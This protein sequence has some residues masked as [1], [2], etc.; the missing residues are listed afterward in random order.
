MIGGRCLL[1]GATLLIAPTGRGVAGEQPA[2]PVPARWSVGDARAIGDGETDHTA[3]FQRLLDE[4]GRAGGGVVEVPA[5]RYVIRGSLS[6]PSGVT[7]QGTYR[8]PPTAR[9]GAVT[10]LTGTVLLAYAGR[11]STNG[12]PFISLAG[13]CA[14][15]SGLI[16]AYP[17]WRQEDVPPVPYPPCVMSRGTENVGVLDC[18]LLNPYEAIRLES[19]HR[20][21][22]RNV[23][24]YPS[25]RGLYVDMCGDIG[26][27]ENVHFWPFGVM[28]KPNNPFCEWVNTQGVAF[29]LA[30]TDWE[31][32]LN[33]FCFGYGIGYRFSQSKHGSANGNFLGI[34]ADSCQ[35]AVVVEQAQ[36][37]GLLISNGEFVGRWSSTDAVCLEIGPAAEGKVSLSNCSF[38]GPID[39]CVWMRSPTGQFTAGACNFLNWDNRGVGSPAIQLDAGRAIIQGCTF[40]Q[41]GLHVQVG[42]EV[43]SAILTANQ[44]SGGFFVENKAGRRA[45]IAL[46]EEGAVQW[47]REALLNYRLQVGAQGD[48]RYLSGWHGRDGGK[49]PSRWSMP[50]SRLV[51]PVAPGERYSIILEAQVPSVAVSPESGLYL[52]GKQLAPLKA[53]AP[54]SAEI[55]PSAEEQVTL[56]LRANGWV[57]QKLN[58]ASRDPRTL[59]VQVFSVTMKASNAGARLFNANTG[60]WPGADALQ[61]KSEKR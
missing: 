18:L 22:V 34:G 7:L 47:T 5:G 12:P 1:L 48:G 21:L 33:T 23:T 57:P 35:R 60:E 52:G 45:Q 38:W 2:A 53:G 19:A 39:R 41:E 8:V 14:A 36:K 16:V 58:A 54:I 27:I 46:N 31:Y 30:R 6:V 3:T 43:T 50:V 37:P 59:G 25:M 55:P 17:E 28:Y 24:G 32:V 13:N 51:L 42:S 4:A 56:E 49:R 26:R 15:I 9:K 11:G 44:A 61:S 10:N 40:D 20:H 29:E